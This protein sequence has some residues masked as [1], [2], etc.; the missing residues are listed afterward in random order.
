MV[1]GKQRDLSYQLQALKFPPSQE[2]FCNASKVCVRADPRALLY[3]NSHYLEAESVCR[4]RL[5]GG[6]YQRVIKEI[7]LS[8]APVET[9]TQHTCGLCQTR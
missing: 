9:N 4:V 6:K 5:R 2:C 3:T 8:E 1:L 7:L